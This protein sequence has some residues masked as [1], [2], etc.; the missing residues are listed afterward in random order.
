MSIDVRTP[1]YAG[2]RTRLLEVI[3]AGPR[4]ILL[5][6][7]SDSADTSRAVLREL[8]LAGQSAVAVD[9]PGFGQADALGTEAILPQLDAFVDELVREQAVHGP[10]VLVGNSLG[11]CAAVRASTRTL[12]VLGVVAIGD[13]AAGH[14]W[15]ASVAAS[16]PGALGLRLLARLVPPRVFQLV[17]RTLLKRIVYGDP[18]LAD[19]H[20]VDAFIAWIL[21][22]GGARGM[23]TQ[24]SRLAA[25]LVEGHRSA[26]VI[27]PLLIVHGTRD[28]IVPVRTS[29][30]LHAVV[31]GS[32]LV[33]DPRWGHCPQHD[34]PRALAELIA[35]F[36]TAVSARKA[37]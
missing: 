37:S 23:C 25:E 19:P 8:D 17:M 18:K 32:Q 1:T 5:H 24:I 36:C 34:E 11:G 9:L 3:G 15:P 29:R 10:V 2:Y 6:G 20:V 12:P 13:P 4:L 22:Q 27:S 28:R 31:P 16:R 7:Y 33:I 26:D 14:W 30:Q 35:T 21:A